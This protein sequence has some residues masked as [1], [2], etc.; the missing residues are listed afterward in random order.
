MS[1]AVKCLTCN[2]TGS[3]PGSH[4]L[5]CASCGAAVERVVFEAEHARMVN[6]HSDLHDLWIAYQMGKAA[7]AA[8]AVPDGWLAVPVKPNGDMAYFGARSLIDGIEKRRDSWAEE[9]ERAYTTMIHLAP[10]VP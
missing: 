10:D 7:G 4:D 2:D 6:G 5:D 1:A 9:A 8:Q 3:L